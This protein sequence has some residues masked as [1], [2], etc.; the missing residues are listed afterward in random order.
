MKKDDKNIKRYT[1]I[2]SWVFGFFAIYLVGIGFLTWSSTSISLNDTGVFGDSFGP[3][4]ALFSGLA[5][6]GVIITVLLQKDEL[7]LQRKELELT[8]NELQGQKEQMKAQNETLKKQ[9]FENTFFELLR[10][11]NE[12]TNSIDVANIGGHYKG[13]DCFEKFYE[14]YCSWH[15]VHKNQDKMKPSKDLVEKS[16]EKFY[17][18]HQSD[19]GHYFRTLYNLVKFVHKSDVQDKRLYT[20]LV[21][22]QLSS[23]ETVLL[24]YNCISSYGAIDFKP[25]VNEYSLLKALPRNKAV[26]FEALKMEYDSSAFV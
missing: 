5:F 18:A 17:E 9:N 12:I 20:N 21:R 11:Q 2:I 8:R 13:R 4:T 25:Y 6:A 16:Y 7:A 15:N 22:A 19:V 3:L 26:D 10:L 23:F 1:W 14:Q 24:F